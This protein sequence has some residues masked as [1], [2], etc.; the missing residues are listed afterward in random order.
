MQEVTENDSG[1]MHGVFG[2]RGVRERFRWSLKLIQELAL[3]VQGR[4][5]AVRLSSLGAPMLG[6][7]FFVCVFSVLW[8]GVCCFKPC[9]FQLEAAKHSLDSQLF[10]QGGTPSA[11]RDCQAKL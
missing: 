2:F 10:S 11:S 5:L 4:G 9:E 7:L 6:F 8:G 1:E 3:R